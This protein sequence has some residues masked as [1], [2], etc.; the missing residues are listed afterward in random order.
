MAVR[1]YADPLEPIELPEPALRPGHALLEILTCGVCF[2][3]VKTARGRMP[4]S[5]RP[6]PPPRPRPRDLRR[7]VR[8]DPPARSSRAPSW[9][10]TTCGRAAGAV[11]AGPAPSSSA[12]TPQALD[13]LHTPGGFQRRIVAPLDRLTVVPGGIDPVHAA[14]LTCALGTAYR[15]VITRGGVVAGAVAVG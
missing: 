8:S 12:A 9:S 13:G 2:T 15:A 14:P 1:D 5:D 4:F 3:D 6:C 7:V 10:S 11:D